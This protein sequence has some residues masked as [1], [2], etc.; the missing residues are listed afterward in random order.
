MDK[1]KFELEIK[2]EDLK[3]ENATAIQ[4][5]TSFSWL[6]LLIIIIL[7]LV[8]LLNDLLK[9]I[10]YLKKNYGFNI[11]KHNHR[12]ISFKNSESINSS[13]HTLFKKDEKFLLNL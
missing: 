10:S 7:F 9:F 6:A 12:S 5:S 8:L 1:I 3:S 11:K 13:N 2:L 4:T